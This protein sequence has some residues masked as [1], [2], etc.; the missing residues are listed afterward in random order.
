MITEFKLNEREK[1][2]AKAFKEKHQHPKV[3]K[4]AI[5]GH[6]EYRFVPT[7]IA[8]VVE[9]HCIICGAHENITDYDS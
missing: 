5:G 8:N 6:I 2:L 3:N 4:G 9:I 1:A 7:S